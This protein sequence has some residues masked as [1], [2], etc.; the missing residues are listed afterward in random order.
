MPSELPRPVAALLRRLG[1]LNERDQLLAYEAI[2]DY[3]AAG[4]KMIAYDEELDARISAVNALQAVADYHGVNVGELQVKQFDAAPEELR[5]GWR[6]G[7]IIK[8]F[9]TWR[10][11]RETAAGRHPRPT[12]RQRALMSASGAMRLWRDDYLEGVRA[13]LETDPPKLG[14]RQYNDWSREHNKTL[15]EG[16]LPYPAY[17]SIHALG[18][19]WEAVLKVARGEVRLDQA[20]RSE[21]K[22]RHSSTTGSHDLVSSIDIRAMTGRPHST[23]QLWMHRDTFPTPVLIIGDRRFWLREDIEA[24][25]SEQPFPKRKPNELRGFYVNRNE[26]AAIL[27]VTPNSMNKIKGRPEPVFNGMTRLW[28]RSEIEQFRDWRNQNLTPRGRPKRK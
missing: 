7:Q 13:W 6:G 17:S 26:A 24:F 16:E 5:G 4:G 18:L 3:L 22:Q 28:L 23:V 8:A 2:R 1:Q 27:G 14:A 19:S 20:Q 11:A 9:D 10:F 12:A 15:Q 21:M 25:V